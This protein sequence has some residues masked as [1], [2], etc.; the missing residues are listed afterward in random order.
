M[1]STKQPV[2]PGSDEDLRYAGVDER[3]RKRMI[4]NRESARRSRMK[5][6]Q[7][8]DGLISQVTQLQNGN[9]LIEQ[10]VN[11]VDN[12]YIKLVS[13]NNVLRAQLVELTDRLCS[14][15]S[16]LRVAEEVSGFAIDIPE[17]PDTLLEP[18]QLPCSVQTV[19]ASANMFQC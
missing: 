13:Q 4:S 15:N 2:S 5:K 17:I 8:L 10:K 12:M 1:A 16:V 18:W 14:L 9:K 7:H 3:K 6:Q 19:A 11:K